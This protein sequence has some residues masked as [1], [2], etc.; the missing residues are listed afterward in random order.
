MSQ[1][2][3]QSPVSK[4]STGCLN[5]RWA[6]ALLE[7]MVAAGLEQLVLSPGARSTPLLIA[8]QRLEA[9]GRLRLTPILDE[10]SAAFFALGLA[11]AT[12][13]PV[14]LLATSGSAPAHWY[15]AV[16]EASEAGLPLLL[17]S[18]DRPPRLHGWGAN[19]TIDQTRLF[20]A[21]V[22]AFHDP[23]LPQAAP[24]ALKAQYALGR[25]VALVSSGKRPGPVHLNLPF[26]EPLVPEADCAESLA[27]PVIAASSDPRAEATVQPRDPEASGPNVRATSNAIAPRYQAGLGTL[28]REGLCFDWPA[29]RGLILCGPGA[30]PRTPVSMATR[31]SLSPA[32]W[33]CAEA[34][35]LPVLVDPLSGLRGGALDE[36]R[37]SPYCISAYDAFLRNS[38]VA[39]ALRPDWVLRLGRAPVSKVLGQWLE[40]VPSILVCEAGLWSDPSHDARFQL[41]APA[42]AVCEALHR[43]GLVDPDPEWLARWRAVERH[44]WRLVDASRAQADP[45]ARSGHSAQVTGAARAAQA[46]TDQA[47]TDRA[48]QA[49]IGPWSE[50][51]V[52]AALRAVIPDGEALFCANSMPIRQLDTWWRAGGRRVTLLGNRGASGIDGYLSTLAGL[53][54][55]GLPCWGLA[56]DLSLCH[57][58][59]GLLLMTRL[60]RPLL[61][62]NN[63]GGHIFDY[64]PQRE[65]PD[66]ERLWQTPQT[67]DL[68]ALAALG[69]VRHW[70]VE[71]GDQLGRALGE[72]GL[73]SGLIECRIDPEASRRAHLAFWEEMRLADFPEALD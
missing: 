11:R 71:N 21:F 39:R 20:G 10:R 28:G 14:A 18:A 23:G 32:L 61:V 6:S 68:Q 51:Q 47:G 44:A 27:E 22:R 31:P 48:E 34:L 70:R 50:A 60:D 33:H 62:L 58:L 55:A 72:I 12:L 4:T 67:L 40:G 30:E 8:A 3:P 38:A 15:P 66:Y 46:G 49:P 35:A 69:G 41:E 26:D 1:S 25:R 52:I 45:W 29:G 43:Q 9:A 5:L 24:A 16:I 53:T 63:G 17:L 57:D 2:A 56:G 64:L 36:T 54:Q 13:R 59:S 73:G 7:G 42:A 65:L 37:I 19:Q